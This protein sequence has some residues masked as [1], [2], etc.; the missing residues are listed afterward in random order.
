M[1][2][3]EEGLSDLRP[4]SI[5]SKVTRAWGGGMLG[6]MLRA[7]YNSREDLCKVQ[8]QPP[9]SLQPPQVEVPQGLSVPSAMGLENS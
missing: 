1:T 8:G 2:S 6:Q 9:V 3:Y 5:L 4:G 7:P